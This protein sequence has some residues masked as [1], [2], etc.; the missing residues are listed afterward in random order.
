MGC[1][2]SAGKSA[3]SADLVEQGWKVWSLRRSSGD[4]DLHLG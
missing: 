1:A 4:V 2:I 3:A